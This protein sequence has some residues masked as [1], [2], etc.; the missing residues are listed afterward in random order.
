MKHGGIDLHAKDILKQIEEIFRVLEEHDIP[1]NKSSRFYLFYKDYSRLLESN[2][3]EEH[4]SELLEGM[5]DFFE[6]K[7]IV[8]SKEIL[9]N[10][11]NELKQLFSGSR[12]PAEDTN[13]LAR[14][15]QYQLYLASRFSNSGMEIN[16]VEPDFNFEYEGE[17]YSV[18]AK[19]ITS[20]NKVIE[21]IKEAEKQILRHDYDGFIAISLDRLLNIANPYILT[22][23]P[24][25][26][27]SATYEL[28]TGIVKELFDAECFES[29]DKK[30][31]GMI[32]TLGVPCFTPIDLSIGYGFNLQLFPLTD[33][34]DIY[35][36]ERIGKIS[37]RLSFGREFEEDDNFS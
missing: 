11:K 9:H 5:R 14:N 12:L 31:K 24:D 7:S 26:L 13:T 16:C 28:L 21:R 3:M 30:V 29:R 6:I 23:N 10:S 25:V 17:I 8:S 34:N 33:P 37:E 20:R 27:S 32:I 1:F 22:N 18:A 35:E 2:N 15:L 19:R 4:F 36:F